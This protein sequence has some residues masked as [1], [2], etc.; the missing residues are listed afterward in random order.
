MEYRVLVSVLVG[1]GG[2]K[3]IKT[4]S[5]IVS[6][7]TDGIKMDWVVIDNCA[8]HDTI[9]RIKSLF[10]QTNMVKSEKNLGF[11]GG[12]NLAF[13]LALEKDVDF[14]F[15]LN[16][17]VRL[18]E[19][20]VQEMTSEGMK[21]PDAAVIGSTIRFA[22]GRIQATGGTLR[23]LNLGIHWITD[24]A[25]EGQK[26]VKEVDAIQG[27]AFALSKAALQKG[28]RL[29]SCLFLGVEE[30]DLACWSKSVSLKSYVVE[31]VEVIHDTNQAKLVSNRWY[32][33][34]LYY[35]YAVR[36]EI[37]VK[38]KYRASIVEYVLS[39]SHT[40]ARV[41]LKGIVFFLR[42]D[43]IV[44]QCILRGILDGFMNHMG[45]AT[46]QVKR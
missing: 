27:A 45:K 13:P 2:D 37:Y 36:N 8:D 42:G 19:N 40:L 24:K 34:P 25:I 21:K 16:D 1:N 18:E 23:F 44:M 3:A 4:I 6:Q 26:N 43:V 20:Y 46:F 15:V 38:R 9:Q 12:N 32:V 35:Y 14:L 5:D 31:H 10:P 7:K 41:V 33:D 28:F 22:N 29:D 30:F 39:V 11:S 17:D